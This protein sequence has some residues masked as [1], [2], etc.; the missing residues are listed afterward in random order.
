MVLGFCN[1]LIT[2]LLALDFEKPNFHKEKNVLEKN[3]TV[4]KI[5]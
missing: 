4:E 2:Y 1:A 3:A 5:K